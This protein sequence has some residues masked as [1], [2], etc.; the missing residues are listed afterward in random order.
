MCNLFIQTAV[1]PSQKRSSQT[2]RLPRGSASHYIALYE[3]TDKHR[4]NLLKTNS[5]LLLL[6]LLLH[7][8]GI[9]VVWTKY[10]NWCCAQKVEWEAQTGMYQWSTSTFGNSCGC[11]HR[12]GH[13][14]VKGNDQTGSPA[15]KVTLTSGLLLG[16]SKVLRSLRRYL[17]AQSQAHHTIHRLEE[18]G[19]E[20]GSAGRPSLKGRERAIVSQTN[21][22]TVSKATL[23]K[24]LRDGGGAPTF[25]GFSERIDTIRN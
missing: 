19:V 5:L 20:R 25:M 16:K 3:D 23:G 21:I 4:L 24:L 13:A 10:Q 2:L 8:V 6:L 18:R 14:G 22:G 12:P 9:P 1:S 11:T 17:W 15:G 7:I